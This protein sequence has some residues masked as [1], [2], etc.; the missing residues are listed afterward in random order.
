MPGLG[1]SPERAAE[2]SSS[3]R[4]TNQ[5]PACDCLAVVPCG[6]GGPISGCNARRFQFRPFQSDL[7]L[8]CLSFPVPGLTKPWTPASSSSEGKPPSN[9]VVAA[10]TGV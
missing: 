9:V 6:K 3:H 1:G 8:Q 5:R 2:C 7:G 4:A 10:R